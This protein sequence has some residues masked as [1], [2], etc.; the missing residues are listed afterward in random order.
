MC[1]ADTVESCLK[2]DIDFDVFLNDTELLI[3]GVTL[4]EKFEG[5]GAG[6]RFTKSY[7][8]GANLL[9]LSSRGE[10]MAPLPRRGIHATGLWPDL[11]TGHL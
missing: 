10:V 9:S 6:D 11:C 5:V 8:V 4:K 7:E 1:Q 2:I 3:D